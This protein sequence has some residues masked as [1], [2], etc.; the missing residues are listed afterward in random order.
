MPIYK[1]KG[2]KE[3]KQKYRVRINYIDSLGNAKQMDRVAYGL[4]EAKQL[5]RELI[6][7]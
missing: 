7:S 5:E 2:K 4:D 1:M 6:I 3:G